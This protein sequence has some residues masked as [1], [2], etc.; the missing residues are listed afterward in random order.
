MIP[1]KQK[2]AIRIKTRVRINSYTT[3]TFNIGLI[4]SAPFLVV[5]RTFLKD[6]FSEQV[7]ILVLFLSAAII[8]TIIQK[9]IRL[10]LRKK[11]PDS[12]WFTFFD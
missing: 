10:W 4:L 1:Q 5:I 3:K 7:V 9:I 12:N 11:S 8:A 6:R 2:D